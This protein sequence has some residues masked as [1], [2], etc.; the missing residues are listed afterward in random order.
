MRRNRRHSADGRDRG[1]GD[2]PRREIAGVGISKA[3]H[4]LA[5]NGRRLRK[6][7]IRGSEGKCNVCHCRAVVG[8]AFA[9]VLNALL[10]TVEGVTPLLFS[11]TFA[12]VLVKF[13][14]QVIVG[15]VPGHMA[16]A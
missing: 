6:G 14:F 1:E 15:P 10:R 8:W 9:Q 12:G 2:D 5:V 13:S 4:V 16:S 11:T 7:G 3:D